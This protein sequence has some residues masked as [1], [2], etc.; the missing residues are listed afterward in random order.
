MIRAELIGHEKRG[1][2][3]KLIDEMI[4]FDKMNKRTIA[5]ILN[6]VIGIPSCDQEHEQVAALEE[7]GFE[8]ITDHFDGSYTGKRIFINGKHDRNYVYL[9]NLKEKDGI[10][11]IRL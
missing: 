9:G 4:S 7:E 11:E 6:K 10:S 8:E 3:S 5:D 2:E 1:K